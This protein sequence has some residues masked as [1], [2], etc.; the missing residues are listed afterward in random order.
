MIAILL[1]LLRIGQRLSKH[2]SRT[3]LAGIAGS[4]VLKLITVSR[5]KLIA[6]I[7]C[8]HRCGRF[9]FL[10]QVIE[11]GGLGC[12]GNRDQ[13]RNNVILSEEG[14]RF[15][16]EQNKNIVLR[17]SHERIGELPEGY[18]WLDYATLNAMVQFNNVLNIQLRNLLSILEM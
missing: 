2:H 1:N 11:V 16:H 17:V 4:H 13:I 12:R 6:L 15:Y 7:L 5:D 9:L 10:I 14:G 8:R 3:E 18:F